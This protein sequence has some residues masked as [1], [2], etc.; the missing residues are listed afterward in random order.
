MKLNIISETEF[1]NYVKTQQCNNFFQSI[2]MYNRYLKSNHECYL[3][4]LID[5]QKIV[6]ATLLVVSNK[7]FGYKKFHAYKGFICNYNDQKIIK[8]F[9]K[10]LKE[11]IKSKKGL[12]LSI[13]PYIK[14]I[15]R[16]S[17]G[18]ITNEVNN[19]IIHQYLLDIGYKY[20]NQEEQVKWT[21]CLDTN[22]SEEILYKEL[23]PNT[24]NKI[25]KITNKL[26]LEI[27]TLTYEELNKFKK[28]T[29][30]TSLRK[31]FSDRSLKYYQSMYKNFKDL[32]KF[33]IAILNCEKYI[34]N[35][36]KD[37]KDYQDK[38]ITN[39]KQNDSLTKDIANIKS[40]INEI[41][42]LKKEQGNEIILSG[43][44]F[45]MYGKE[46]VYL[47]SGS[48][49][50]YMQFGGQYILQWDMIKYASQ[51]KYERYNFFGISGNFDKSS[52]DYGVYEFKKGF[53]GY[54]EELLGTYEIKCH[55][56]YTI[57]HI[58]KKI[59]KLLRR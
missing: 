23:K 54:V 48:Y 7:F 45:I 15:S 5:D 52:K 37:L 57:Y 25:N 18:A 39:K 43:A 3:L 27:K 22:K 33:K 10:L 36:K 29:S 41:E 13:D 32:I 46:I 21:Y 42:Q 4:G 26:E 24:R 49:K 59:K 2:N 1:Q 8:T 11:F 9:T 40:K 12:S 16:D 20:L 55:K 34:N 38:S 44:M 6:G 51:K 58:L 31:S 50:E 56:L 14:R 47:F 35:L 28:I 53:G 30:S 19:E 17:S